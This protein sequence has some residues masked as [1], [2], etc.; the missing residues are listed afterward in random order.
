M[1]NRF[2]IA[3][4]YLEIRRVGLLKLF[5]TTFFVLYVTVL[6]GR[7]LIPEM[8]RHYFLWGESQPYLLDRKLKRYLEQE[9]R[10]RRS[11]YLRWC[12]IELDLF[13]E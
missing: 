12:S 6:L 8:F 3:R 4:I 1:I 10:R 9:A 11:K 2:V 7:V 5:K 13:E